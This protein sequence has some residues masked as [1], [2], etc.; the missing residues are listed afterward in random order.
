MRR[1][2]SGTPGTNEET[3][4]TPTVTELLE[5]ALQ[6]ERLGRFAEAREHLRRVTSMDGGPATLEA[7]KPRYEK[8]P[9]YQARS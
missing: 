3:L 1:S 5:L 7:A 4:S 2:R 8:T 6:A 9:N